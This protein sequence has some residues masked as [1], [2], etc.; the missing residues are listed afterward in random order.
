MTIVGDVCSGI[1][2]FFIGDSLGIMS[3]IGFSE[4]FICC[5]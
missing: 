4:E 3:N 2:V 1:F 5:I